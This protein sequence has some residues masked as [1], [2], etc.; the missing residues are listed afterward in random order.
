MAQVSNN[1]IGISPTERH[2]V[3]ATQAQ[4]I[5]EAAV[6]SATSINVPQNIAVV[7]PFGLLVAFFRMD[8]AYPGVFT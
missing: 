8:N 5:L 7:D 1:G 6:Q 2:I 3:N 4:T